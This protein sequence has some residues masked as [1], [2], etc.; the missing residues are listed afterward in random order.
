MGVK[1]ADLQ[2]VYVKSLDLTRVKALAASLADPK[3]LSDPRVASDLIWLLNGKFSDKAAK[4]LAAF[5]TEVLKDAAAAQVSLLSE[6]T[7]A[8]VDVAE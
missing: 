3:K 7:T 4:M 6:L 2:T 1:V 8:G 5:L